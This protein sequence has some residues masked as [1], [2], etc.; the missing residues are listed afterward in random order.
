MALSRRQKLIVIMLLFYWPSVFIFAHIP[1]PDLV[2]QAGVSDKSIHFVAYWIL[3][4]LLFCVVNPDKKVKWSKVVVWRILFLIAAYGII[5]EWLQGYV[6]GR[7]SDIMDFFLDVAGAVAS[8]VVLT[9]FAFWPA[10]LVITA[11]TIFILTNVTRVDL[12]DLLPVTNRVLHLFAYVF[13]TILWI[14][15]IHLRTNYSPQ[16]IATDEL[17]H[18]PGF[19]YF[20]HAKVM[21]V[22]RLIVMLALPVGLLLATKLGSLV[23][24]RDFTCPEMIISTIGI[25]GVVAVAGVSALIRRVHKA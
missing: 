6:A 22:K 17:S 11:V 10:L 19:G 5:D 25:G 20:S 16:C 23:L 24:G 18:H 21:G 2:Q 9:F 13:F 8:L 4:F 14:R 15:Y 12:A 3:A 7:N 1:I